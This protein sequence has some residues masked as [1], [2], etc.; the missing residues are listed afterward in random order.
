MKYLSANVSSWP[1]GD[2][3]LPAWMSAKPPIADRIRVRSNS[4]N[5]DRDVG[6][7]G[8]D[9][10]GHHFRFVPKAD[11]DQSRARRYG[12]FLCLLRVTIEPPFA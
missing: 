12:S 10:R 4:S 8:Q 1:K 9:T 5:D 11:I 2:K 7:S 6:H 3:S